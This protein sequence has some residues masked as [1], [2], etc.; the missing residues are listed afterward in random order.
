MRKEQAGRK[1]GLLI[2][3]AAAIVVLGL[4]SYALLA[5]FARSFYGV[6][7]TH[8]RALE[9]TLTQKLREG[10]SKSEILAFLS[11][12]NLDWAPGS[13][14]KLRAFYPGRPER[15]V[16]AEGCD[17]VQA[18]FHALSALCVETHD[19]VTMHF[20]KDGHVVSWRVYHRGE[21]C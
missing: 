9:A 21:G 20:A 6:P 2:G 3:I 15:V 1:T 18:A 17:D 19:V 14:W 10:R 8:D 5:V 7:N 12:E 11:S 13:T 4:I 16:C